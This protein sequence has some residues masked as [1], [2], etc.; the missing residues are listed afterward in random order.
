M[1]KKKKLNPNTIAKND[2]ARFE[3]HISDSVEAGLKLEG[4]EV[5][6]LRAGKASITESYVYIR[7]GE[8][9]ISGMTIQDYKQASTHVVCNP[10]RV[11]KLLLSKKEINRL[12]GLVNQKGMTLVATSLYWSGSWAKLNVGLAKGKDLHDKRAD[13]KNRDW[14][15]NKQRILKNG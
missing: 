11:R 2:R 10:T 15:R 1:A 13:E 5:K 8:A 3:Y 4:W 12:V 7:D 6:S 9:F 14:E